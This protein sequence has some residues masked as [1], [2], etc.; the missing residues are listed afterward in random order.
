VGWLMSKGTAIV[1]IALVWGRTGALSM[2]ASLAARRTPTATAPR[3][4]LSKAALHRRS[5]TRSHQGIPT[6]RRQLPVTWRVGGS[7]WTMSTTS[8]GAPSLVDGLP[9]RFVCRVTTRRG[10][11]VSKCNLVLSLLDRPPPHAYHAC[12]WTMMTCSCQGENPPH[13]HSHVDVRPYQLE[14]NSRLTLVYECPNVCTNCTRDSHFDGGAV[15]EPSSPAN[16]QTGPILAR[17]MPAKEPWLA[18]AGARLRAGKLVAFPTGM[19]IGSTEVTFGVGVVEAA[20][21][22]RKGEPLSSAEK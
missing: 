13:G 11:H 14:V 18:E 20:H 17:V 10:P 4:V 8:K 3:A 1:L 5:N 15:P 16:S 9:K 19:G 2:L 21:K 6:P 12:T 7:T 22:R